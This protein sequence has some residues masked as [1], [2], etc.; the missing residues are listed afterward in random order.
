MTPNLRLP[1]LLG[2][3]RDLDREGVLFR[4]REN[5]RPLLELLLL[6]RDLEAPRDLPLD[7]ALPLDLDLEPIGP[8]RSIGSG[9]STA[10]SAR[11]WESAY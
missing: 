4:V 9:T 2:L 8:S 11:S 10:G 6:E 7:G 1:T 3:G 5:E